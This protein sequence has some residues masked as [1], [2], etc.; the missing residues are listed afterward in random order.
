MQKK[1][2][3]YIPIT[4]LNGFTDAAGKIFAYRKDD[5]SKPLHVQPNQI[6]FERYYYSQPLADGGRDNNSLEDFFSTVEAAWPTLAERL[7]SGSATG[8]DFESLFTFMCLMRVR[9]PAARDMVELSLSEQ[10]KAEARLLDQKGMLPPKPAGYENILDH[11]EVSIDPHQSLHA[12]PALA[13]G[14]SKVLDSLEFDVLHNQT[15][16]SFI[17]SDNPVIYFEP[18]A[19][20]EGVLPYQVRPPHGLE[21]FPI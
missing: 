16:L 11:L 12:M 19:H 17:T 18:T 4:Y 9:V 14:F 5:I 20:E 6:A 13:K 3:H 2:H 8:T 10:V 15:S 7:R 21:Q 1:R